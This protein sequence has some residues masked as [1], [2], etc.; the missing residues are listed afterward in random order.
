MAYKLNTLPN[1]HD[2][3]AAFL[4]LVLNRKQFSR[5]C[6]GC[7]KMISRKS[8]PTKMIKPTPKAKMTCALK[9]YVH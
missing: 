5:F 2:F 3:I 1:R 4:V 7:A 6:V 8:I 9:I